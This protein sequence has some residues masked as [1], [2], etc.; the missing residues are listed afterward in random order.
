MYYVP[1]RCSRYYLC[2]IIGLLVFEFFVF[3]DQTLWQ[4]SV[5]IGQPEIHV[6]YAIGESI[7]NGQQ[8]II[9]M[10]TSSCNTT[11]TC[12]WSALWL[13]GLIHLREP[14][15]NVLPV[16]RVGPS[17]VILLFWM[18]YN[19]FQHL[20]LNWTTIIDRF[21]KYAWIYWKYCT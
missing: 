7:V 5:A 14:V 17:Q 20:R 10:A 15:F 12:F 3:S 1:S 2:S 13:T 4:R 11:G 18:R 9:P 21:R 16:S 6:L 8:L 19:Y